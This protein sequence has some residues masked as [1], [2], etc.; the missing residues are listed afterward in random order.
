MMSVLLNDFMY[1]EKPFEKQ[2]QKYIGST[3]NAKII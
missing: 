3:G 1:E 2:L